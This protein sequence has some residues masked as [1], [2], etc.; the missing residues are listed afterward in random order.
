MRLHLPMF[1]RGTLVEFYYKQNHD[2]SCYTLMSVVCLLSWPK[3]SL[4]NDQ[5]MSATVEDKKN[6]LFTAKNLPHECD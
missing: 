1:G 6:H 2:Q 5:S 3:L 4:N